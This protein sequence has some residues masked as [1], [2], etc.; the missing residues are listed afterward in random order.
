MEK[1]I[2]ELS[3]LAAEASACASCRLFSGR[4]NAVFGDGNCLSPL[5]LIGEAPGREEDAQGIPFVGRSGKL[6]DKLLTEEIGITRADYYI[7]NI[8]KCRPP[9][10][11]NPLPDEVESC[12]HFITEQIR[13]IKPKVILTLGNF[14][15]QAVLESKEGITKLRERVFDIVIGNVK[16]KVV[17]TYHPSYILRAGGMAMAEMRS[18]MI[19]VKKL[20][21]Q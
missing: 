14:A 19:R 12:R 2:S 16:V 20:L 8:I 5:F 6:L 15:S 7:A 9:E 3:S 1:L 11:R 18:D 21:R 17:P 4:K 13:L 10:N